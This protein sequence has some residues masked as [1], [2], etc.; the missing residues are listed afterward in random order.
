MKVY[1]EIT[2]SN[3][4]FEFWGSA[5]EFEFDPQ[6]NSHI[7]DDGKGGGHYDTKINQLREGHE[8][9]WVL[10]DILHATAEDGFT[11]LMRQLN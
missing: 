3:R 6:M 9:E 8:A 11:E 4:N 2:L 1:N 5:K 7:R 10:A